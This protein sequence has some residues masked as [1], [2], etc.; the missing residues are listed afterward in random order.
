M[1]L[2]IDNR[3]GNLNK[4]TVIDEC[5]KDKLIDTLQMLNGSNHTLLSI[6]RKDKC[7]MNVGGGPLFFIVNFTTS[8]GDNMTLLNPEE[9]NSEEIVELCAGGQYAEFPKSIVVDI[10]NAIKSVVLFYEENEKTLNWNQ[11]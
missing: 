1:K 10:N 5:S 6:E 9:D 11:E 2:V 8:A 3:A 4:D 7:R